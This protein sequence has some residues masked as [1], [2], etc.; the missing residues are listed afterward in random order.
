MVPPIFGASVSKTAL[1]EGE[2]LL[3]KKSADGLTLDVLPPATST[4]D[5][6]HIKFARWVPGGVRFLAAGT[7]R[8]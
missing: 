1:T 2:K 4:S 8:C 3:M 6:G 5:M 7:T